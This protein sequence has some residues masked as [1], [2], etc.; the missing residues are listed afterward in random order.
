LLGQLPDVNNTL[1]SEQHR[2]TVAFNYLI[3]NRG[4]MPPVRTT[5]S[6]PELAANDTADPRDG[7]LA[8]KASVLERFITDRSHFERFHERREMPFIEDP[9]TRRVEDI[10]QN[11]ARLNASE[12]HFPRA[13]VSHP[14]T[15]IPMSLAG[16]G[17]EE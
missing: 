2:R 13:G 5:Q 3:R 12:V 15:H 11:L 10:R 14:D 8:T 6:W 9:A 4:S 16:V 7:Y 1:W 17:V